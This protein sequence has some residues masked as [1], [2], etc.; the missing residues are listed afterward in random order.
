MMS[1]LA[2]HYCSPYNFCSPFERSHIKWI[3]NLCL[4]ATKSYYMNSDDLIHTHR[5][6][7][8][9]TDR[10]TDSEKSM[11]YKYILVY[12]DFHAFSYIRSYCFQGRHVLIIFAGARV[13]GGGRHVTH[14]PQQHL[15]FNYLFLF[16]RNIPKRINYI[17]K[18]LD[19]HLY[20]F[21]W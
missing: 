12:L 4:L 6:T 16:I 13:G 3:T 8:R 1:Q 21:C 20:R 7:D 5:H 18:Y 11:K 10:H 14:Q 2:H 17:M 15:C 9:Q 19:S